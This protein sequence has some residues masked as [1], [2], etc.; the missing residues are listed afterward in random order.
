MPSGM[1]AARSPSESARQRDAGIGESEDRQDGERDPG[2]DGVLEFF[3]RAFAFRRA[4][5]KRNGK[6]GDDARKRRMHA[7]FQHAD[8]HE[9]PYE[10]VRPNRA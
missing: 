8:P 5:G 10:D 6:R 7:R 4:G 2:A 9:Q 1:G 3:E